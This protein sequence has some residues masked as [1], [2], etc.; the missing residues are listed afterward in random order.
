QAV[1]QR[2]AHMGLEFLHLAERGDHAEVE[3][4]A[5]TRGQRF[6]APR[7]APAILRDDALEVA[8]E[9]VGAGERAVDI[10]LAQY[11]APLGKP[12]VVRCLVHDVF[13]P[14]RC[15]LYRRQS[16]AACVGSTR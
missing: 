7:L 1:A 4:R 13:L 15:T 14:V 3:D 12:T 11:L 8:I 16:R 5:L 10:V 2:A 9:V 6:V